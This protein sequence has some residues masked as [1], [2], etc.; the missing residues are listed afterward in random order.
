MITAGY[1]RPCASVGQAMRA[2][3]MRLSASP[4]I[5]FSQLY[6]KSDQLSLGSHSLVA[7]PRNA[8]REEVVPSTRAVASV[9]QPL[10]DYVLCS[11]RRYKLVR[12]PIGP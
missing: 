9:F 3:C 7:L 6:S 4:I 2:C 11:P 5:Y 12:P 10:A 1:L 8:A